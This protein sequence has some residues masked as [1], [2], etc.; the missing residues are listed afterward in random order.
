MSG[1]GKYLTELRK[2][3]GHSSAK[4]FHSWLCEQGDLGCNYSYYSRIEKDL[5]LPSSSVVSTIASMV[6]PPHDDAIVMAYCKALFPSKKNLFQIQVP[7][8]AAPPAE[9]GVVPTLS[10]K[11]TLSPLQV[12]TLSSTKRHY[13][14]FL[15]STLARRELSINEISSQIP[16]QSMKTVFNEL[17]EVKIVRGE[18]EAFIAA[19]HELKFPPADN[20]EL[21]AT[22]AKLDEWDQQIAFDLGLKQEVKRFLFRRVSKR[23]VG[24]IQS[25]CALLLDLIRGAEDVDPAHNDEVVSFSINLSVGKIPG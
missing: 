4:G 6:G 15:I 22:Y 10:K 7:L 1:F 23:Y 2:S 16:G 19:C 5:L 11:R 25:H 8:P 14:L 24:M 18:P 9:E 21:K 13:L 17:R 3:L 20:D 12:A